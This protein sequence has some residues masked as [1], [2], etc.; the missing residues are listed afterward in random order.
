MADGKT[1]FHNR[2]QGYIGAVTINEEGRREVVA[3]EPGGTV[4]LDE[5]EERLTA[6]APRDPKDNPFVV[7]QIELRDSRTGDLLETI[8]AARLSVTAE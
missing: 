2:T 5:R 3:V 6:D 8:T 7:R 4:W 1:E